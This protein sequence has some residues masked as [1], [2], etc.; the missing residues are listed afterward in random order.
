MRDQLVLQTIVHK[1]KL[2]AHNF[3]TFAG[4]FGSFIYNR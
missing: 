2:L 3:F 4:F 1:K